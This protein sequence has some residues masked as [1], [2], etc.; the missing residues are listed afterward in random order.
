MVQIRGHVPDIDAAALETARQYIE[1]RISEEMFEDPS[2]PL[3]VRRLVTNV[4]RWG[5]LNVTNDPRWTEGKSRLNNSHDPSK[6]E[7]I[8]LQTGFR[9]STT[10]RG[11]RDSNASFVIDL[12][13]AL[14]GHPG[15]RQNY[16]NVIVRY[17]MM[18]FG[19]V[20]GA[21]QSVQPREQQQGVP[22]F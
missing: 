21:D 4:E 16:L 15:L 18:R 11:A 14:P 7:D 12:N 3:N 19:Q 9:V 22:I 17:D 6:F 8:P 2:Q 20:A 5:G 1:R 13:G 10:V